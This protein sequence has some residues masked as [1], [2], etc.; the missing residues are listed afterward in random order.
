ME[1][2]KKNTCLAALPG[3]DIPTLDDRPLKYDTV[4]Q[5]RFGNKRAAQ[6]TAT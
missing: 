5:G 2:N 6:V 3:A 4:K 1:A